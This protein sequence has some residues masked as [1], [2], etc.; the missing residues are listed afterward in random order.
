MTCRSPPVSA[1]ST[2]GH[3][4]DYHEIYQQLAT[5]EFPWDIYQALSF[6]LLRTYAVP[7]IG[8]LLHRTGE[9]TARVQERY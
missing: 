2:S 8:Q 7:S 9:F 4:S 3:D 1:T 6:A 5:L